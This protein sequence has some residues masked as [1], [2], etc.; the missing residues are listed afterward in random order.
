MPSMNVNL[1]SKLDGRHSIT[2]SS[3]GTAVVNDTNL[4]MYQLENLIR[5]CKATGHSLS[6]V[7]GAL[8]IKNSLNA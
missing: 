4:T 3:N 7:S 2:A 6:I 1:T 8:T 5:D